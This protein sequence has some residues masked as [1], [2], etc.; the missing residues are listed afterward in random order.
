MNQ[1]DPNAENDQ[2]VS[3]FAPR[4]YLRQY[5]SLPKLAVDDAELFKHFSAWLKRSGRR[6][7]TVVDIGC[8]PTIHNTFAI[9]PYADRIDLADYLDENLFEIQRWLD[10]A[11]D[12]HLWDA[13]FRGVMACQ[14]IG[15]DS[16][17][18]RKELYRSCVTALRR[19]DLR[20]PFPLGEAVSYDLVTSF[21]CAECVATSKSDWVA[22]MERMLQM[23]DDGGAVFVAALRE[24]KGYRVLGRWFPSVPVNESD[25]EELLRERGY[26]NIQCTV[27]DAPDWTDDGFEQIVLVSASR[28][29]ESP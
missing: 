7:H 21:F 9:A 19:C 16:L 15:P 12:A 22:M 2:Y 11:P 17:D 28:I 4:E 18:D 29:P 27:V 6:F 25:F 3:D 26:D 14:E 13:L 23:V 20:E 24:S 5:Y 10:A 8:G 1:S